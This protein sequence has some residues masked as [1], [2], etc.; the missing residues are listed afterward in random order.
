MLASISLQMSQAKNLW[1]RKLSVTT[2]MV[3]K[4]LRSQLN[5]LPLIVASK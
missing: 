5:R 1:S 3:S 2:K 4:G